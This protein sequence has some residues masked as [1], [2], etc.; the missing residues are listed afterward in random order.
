MQVEMVS[1]VDREMRAQIVADRV[2]GYIGM[3]CR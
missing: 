2:C 3:C 1:A